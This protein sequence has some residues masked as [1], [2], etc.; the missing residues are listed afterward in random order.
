MRLKC[1]LCKVLQREAYWCAARSPNIIDIVLMPQGLHNTPDVLRAEVQKEADKI[2]DAAGNRYDA[3]LLGY[4]LCSNGVAGIS[5]KTEMIIPRAHDCITLL[6]GSRRRYQEYFDSHRGT[7]WYSVGWLENSPMPGP[8]RL[9]ALKAEYTEKY[10][11]DNAEFL[12][13]TEQGWM[14][15]YQWATFVD[16]GLPG[17]DA[18]KIYTRNCASHLHWQ[19]DEVA[20]DSGLMQR[21]FDGR[22]SEDEFLRIL[23]GQVIR[24]DISGTDII[25]T[26]PIG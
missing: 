8:D 5:C 25:T 20:G 9:N 15:E 7:Y 6:L 13:E 22:W 19:Y 23:P 16:W 4:G 2:H 14:K 24:Q 18:Q 1:I 12:M 3:I 17:T 21:F 10:G 26:E 11:A